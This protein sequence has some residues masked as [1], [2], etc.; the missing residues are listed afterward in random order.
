MKDLL[1][2][3]IVALI[4][5]AYDAQAQSFRGKAGLNLANIIE[6][7]GPGYSAN[8]GFKFGATVEFPSPS[9]FS[10]ETGLFVTQKGFK[11]DYPQIGLVKSSPIYLEVPLNLRKDF[12]SLYVLA[13]PYV[14]IGIAGKHKLGSV[15]ADIEWSGDNAVYQRF[16]YGLSAGL[17]FKID[18]LELELNYSLGLANCESAGGGTG[19]HSVIGITAGYKFGGK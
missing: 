2:L 1:K 7:G 19:H 10:Y 16:D 14:G 4:V 8:V 6:K 12:K 11:Y 13:G 9:G 15:S 3:L 17:G 18:K 5:I